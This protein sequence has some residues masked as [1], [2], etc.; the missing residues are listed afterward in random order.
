ME[1]LNPDI[2]AAKLNTFDVDDETYFA[3]LQ[4]VEKQ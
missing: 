4:F 1:K 3:A 2:I